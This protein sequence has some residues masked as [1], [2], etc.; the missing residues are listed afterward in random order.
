VRAG[1]LAPLLHG[2]TETF[3]LR[4]ARTGAIVATRV[5]AALDSATRRRGLL[6]RDGLPEGTALVIAPSNAVHTFRMRFAIDVIF[7]RRDGRVTKVR[8]AMPARRVA[9]SPLAFAVVETAAGGSAGVAPGDYLELAPVN[10]VA[11]EQSSTDREDM[12][13]TTGRAAGPSEGIGQK[14]SSASA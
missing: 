2:G 12:R 11:A 1:F 7:A 4:N 5:E 6:G 8:A 10:P 14:I 9:V 3:L 13:G